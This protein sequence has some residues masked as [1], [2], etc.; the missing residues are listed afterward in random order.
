MSGY[1]S[2]KP[3]GLKHISVTE[4]FKVFINK[5]EPTLGSLVPNSLKV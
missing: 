2:I 4:V 3:K 5:V 1:S